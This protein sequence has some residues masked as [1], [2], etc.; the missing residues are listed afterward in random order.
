MNARQLSFFEGKRRKEAGLALV[1]SHGAVW[2]RKARAIAVLIAK[3]FGE[4]TSDDVLHIIGDIPKDLHVNTV[5]AIFHGKE[6]E[7]V[8]YTQTV[9]PKGH[10]RVISRWKLKEG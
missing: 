6:W 8:G 5:G 4:V 1:E 9:R 3:Y 10:A 7:R 2:L